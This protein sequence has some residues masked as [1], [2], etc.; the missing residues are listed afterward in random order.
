MFS[1][2]LSLFKSGEPPQDEFKHLILGSARWSGEDESWIG[3]YKGT[4]FSLAYEGRKSPDDEL[5]AYA[6]DILNDKV[7]VDSSIGEAKRQAT[8]EF[9]PPYSDEISSLKLG[10]VHF[11]RHKGVGRIIADLEGGRDFRCWRIEWGGKKCEGIG[12]DT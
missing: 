3:E 11:Y 6:L 1:K 2:I 8:A 4:R 7:W 12:F 5:V 10:T 9:G